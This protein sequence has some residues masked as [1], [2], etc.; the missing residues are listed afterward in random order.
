ME[1]NNIE[2]F[3]KY[4]SKVKKRTRRL[5]ACVPPDKIEWTYH[6]KKYTIG[7]MIRHL[8][9]AERFMFG[10]TIQNKPSLYEGCGTEYA[11]GYENVINYYNQMHEET[12]AILEQISPEQL[13]DKCTTPGGTSIT[14]WKWLRALV[15]HEIHH[16]GQLY[17]YLGILEIEVPP[18]YGL[19]AEE[20]ARRK[21]A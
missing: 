4:Y 5:L 12:I 19:T 7:E 16:R 11:N 8:A 1:I 2:A 13:N 18:L 17:T 10:E 9:N 15:E 20:V 14:T 3:I 21:G 6:P